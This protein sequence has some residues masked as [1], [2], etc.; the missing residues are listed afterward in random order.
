MINKIFLDQ[1]ATYEEIEFS[2]SKI[3]YIYGGNGTGKTTISKVIAEDKKYSECDICYEED[4]INSIVCNKDFVKKHFSQSDSIKGIFTLGKDNK[5]FKEKIEEKNNQINELKEKRKNDN[6]NKEFKEEEREEEMEKFINEIWEIKKKYEVDF[7]E[8][9]EGYIGSKKAFFDKCLKES[10]EN[11]YEL[12]KYN[13]II[14]KKEIIF[15]KEPEKYERLGKL[16]FEKIIELEEL[17]ILS[18]PIIGK[19]NA[20]IGNLI[21][22]LKNS[23]WVN[24]GRKYLEQSKNKCPF[25]QQTINS[26][27]KKD[28]EDFFDESYKE[29][30]EKIKKLRN[31]Y[32]ESIE[33]LFNKIE[34]LRKK[35]IKIIYLSILEEK[36]QILKEKAKRN[37]MIIDEK[38]KNPSNIKKLDYISNIIKDINLEIDEFN[39]KIETNNKIIENIKV[40]KKNLKY[41]MWRYI[42]EEYKGNIERYNKKIKGLNKGLKNLNENIEI[43]DKEIT[44]IEKEIELMESEITSIEYT[45]NEINKILKN[46]GF[47]SFKIEKASEKG[48]YKIVRPDGNCVKETLSEGEYNFIT[49]LYFY[50]MIKGSL[51]PTGMI[52]D[53]IVVIDD[54]V[55]SLDSNILFI[56]SNLVRDIIDDCKNDCK[57]G[58]KQVFLMTHN[59]YFHKEVTFNMN[60]HYLKDEK[61]W[62]IKKINEL[63]SIEQ[64]DKNPIQTTYEMLW[65]EIS[66]IKKLIKLLFLIHLEEF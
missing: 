48:F 17:D 28:I 33:D 10:E 6:D 18:K 19:D 41:K 66:D 5:K 65:T 46:F 43:K 25:C 61:F 57:N 47:N 50:K 11:K 62:I 8:A 29:E 1:V 4:R 39:S 26:E 15:D 7:R 38:L 22:Q 51:N 14:K 27:I 21:K 24:S 42:V 56:I 36:I 23:D 58:I 40:E 12:I 3:N 54:P 64:Y 52:K 49:F 16:N 59:V 55:S 44:K 45:K 37:L 63:S 35:D 2:P 60:K 20:Q 32:E 13:E 31:Y 30:Y 9:F 34:I 53:K